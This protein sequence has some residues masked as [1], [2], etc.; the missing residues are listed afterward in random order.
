MNTKT[1]NIIGWVLTAILAFAFI[2]SASMKLTGGEQA[3]KGAAGF[4]ISLATLKMLGVIE[5]VSIL[6]F[7]IPRTGMLGL[8][9]LSAYLGG[10]IATHLEHHLPITAP[11][12]LQCLLWITAT[13]RFPELSQR[14][15]GKVSTV[16]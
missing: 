13:I 15:S 4:G 8:L 2:A 11:V 1:R 7:I 6:L 14:L 9:L 10:A 12:V 3:A 16:K 5:I